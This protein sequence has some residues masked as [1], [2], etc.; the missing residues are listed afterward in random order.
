MWTLISL[1]VVLFGMLYWD[2]SKRLAHRFKMDAR[3]FRVIV[4]AL[5]IGVLMDVLL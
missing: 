5:V 2:L 4:L 1:L 3:I